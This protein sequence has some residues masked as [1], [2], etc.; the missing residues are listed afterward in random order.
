MDFSFFTT[1]NKSGY[2]TKESWLKKNQ[3]ELYDKIINHN[4]TSLKDIS[5]KEK[6]WFYFNGISEQP[7]CISCENKVKFRNRLDKPYG[8]FCSLQCANNNKKLLLKRQKQANQIKFGVD[9]YPNHSDFVNKQKK[10][11][12]LKYKNENYNNVEKSKQTKLLRYNDKNYNN[13]EKYKKTNLKKYNNQNFSKSDE[14][15]KQSEIKYISLYPT[16]NFKKINKS[17]VSVKCGGCNL[18]YKTNKQLIYERIKRNYDP[19]TICNPIGNQNRSELEKQFCEFLDHNKIEYFTN[20]KIGEQNIEIDILLTKFNIGIEIN[21]VY[22]HN[23][24]FK[25]KTFHLNKTNICKENDIDLIHIFEDEWLYKK[26]IV[27]S[28]ILNKV[29]KTK[30]KIY[31]RNCVVKEISSSDLS[32]FLINNHIQGNVQSSVRLGLFLNEE[33]LSVMSF[34]KG[35]VLMSGKKNEWELNRFCNKIN[36]TIIGG[37][38]KLLSYFK[39]TYNPQFIISYSDIRLYNG[40]MYSN[41][42]FQ[43]K[44]QS[45]PNYWYVVNGI[46]KHRFNYRKSSLVKEGFDIKKTEKQIMLERKIYKIYDCGN[47]RWE[48]YI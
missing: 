25:D 9:F 11:K 17:E 18:I 33:L 26:E 35:R 22:W 38:S 40:I 36:Y 41:L 3:K 19:C 43:K 31:G 15:K 29:N 34:S 27:K 20:K 47:I 4:K 30:N 24:L 6:I 23:E 32:N 37:S 14:Y 44:S 8:D 21:G 16:L 12:L 39:K 10:T 48:L 28:I 45:L 46:R 5:F 7:K 42:G 1:D 13:I 2:K